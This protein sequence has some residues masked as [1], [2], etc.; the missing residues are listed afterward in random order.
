MVIEGAN[1]YCEGVTADRNSE[2]KIRQIVSAVKTVS[3]DSEVSVR[4]LKA[5]RVYEGLLWGKAADT[6][7]GIYRRG[8]SLHHVAESLLLQ[9]R[10]EC[11]KV[12]RSN[13]APAARDLALAG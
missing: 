3:Q 8:P 1:I 4:F 12:W 9:V 10:K 13:R 6:P 11:L 5:G 2:E 7:L